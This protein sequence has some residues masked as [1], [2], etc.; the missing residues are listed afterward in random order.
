ML[1]AI[2][3]PNLFP[4][5]K[6]VQKLALADLW[7]VL[8]DVQ[9]ARQEYQNRAFL[10]PDR[11]GQPPRWCTV[12]VTLPS[13]RSSIIRDVIPN[14]GDPVEVI[15]RGLRASF[16]DEIL[17]EKLLSALRAGY[18]EARPIATLGVASTV[19][20]I[21]IVQSAPR[22][23]FASELRATPEPKSAGLVQLCK[24]VGAT[25]Y[26]ADSGAANYLDEMQ[27]LDVGIDVIW[28]VWRPPNGNFPGVHLRNGSGLNVLMRDAD[29]FAEATAVCPVSRHRSR[30]AVS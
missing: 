4:R 28:Q 26:L 8:D 7:I 27:M 18:E 24:T 15:E 22:V 13:G 5:L 29:A 21:S 3:Q 16:S 9:F 23:L 10:C 2:H 1:V 20:M 11:A 17:T 25:T 30:A 6:V 19:E 12:P 14:G